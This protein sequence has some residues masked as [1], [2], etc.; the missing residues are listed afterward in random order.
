MRV[1]GGGLV[2]G[3]VEVAVGGLLYAA[4]HIFQRHGIDHAPVL[5]NPVR[6]VVRGAVRDAFGAVVD[7]AEAAAG[8]EDLCALLFAAVP[9]VKI[10]VAPV[11]IQAVPSTCDRL[12]HSGVGDAEQM[13]EG[14]FTCVDLNFFGILHDMLIYGV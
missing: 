7:I 13:P 6:D 5:E 14:K 11:I 2:A 8:K 3:P 10:A 4:D 1:D 12:L 9:G